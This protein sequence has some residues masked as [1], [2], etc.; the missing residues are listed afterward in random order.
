MSYYRIMKQVEEKIAEAKPTKRP[1]LTG[2]G[3]LARSK[4]P[5]GPLRATSD[6]ITSEIADYIST[7]RQQK[8]ELMNGGR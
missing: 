8:E 4:M 1:S 5:V 7:I 6:D 2:K 3:L